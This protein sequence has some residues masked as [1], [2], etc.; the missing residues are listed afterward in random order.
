MSEEPPAK[1]QKST[2]RRAL[3]CTECKRRK[4]KCGVIGK[5]PCDSCIKRGKPGDCVWEGITGVPGDLPVVA[6]PYPSATPSTEVTVLQEQVRQLLDRVDR[7]ER[8]PQS[9]STSLENHLSTSA[10]HHNS[11]FSD[12]PGALNAM[13]PQSRDAIQASG[14]SPK[15]TR[16]VEKETMELENEIFGPGLRPGLTETRSLR[17]TILETASSSVRSTQQQLRTPRD[18]IHIVTAPRASIDTRVESDVK[19][20]D[21][22]TLLRPSESGVGSEL[23]KWYFEGP[24]HMGWHVIH[25]FHF[26]NTYSTIMTLSLE[27][28]NETDRSW[29]AIYYMILAN[30]VRFAPASFIN[31][32]FPSTTW[33]LDLLPD[34]LHQISLDELDDSD[35]Q[36]VPQVRHIQVALLYINYLFHFGDSP[37]K[38]NLALRH[39]D[40]A[41]TTA[42]WLS[43][44]ILSPS[45][46][47]L[48]PLLKNDPALEGLPTEAAI[49]LAKQLFAML[50]FLDGTIYKRARVWRIQSTASNATQAPANLTDFQSAPQYANSTSDNVDVTLMAFPGV[51]PDPDTRVFTESSLAILGSVFANTIRQFTKDLSTEEMSYE[52]ILEFSQGLERTL[53]RVPAWDNLQ[54]DSAWMIY[55]VYSSINNRILRMHR[56]YMHKGYTDAR[57]WAARETSIQAASRIIQAQSRI[58]TGLRPAF[59]KRWILGAS[60]ILALDALLVLHPLCAHTHSPAERESVRSNSLYYIST[61]KIDI[62]DKDDQSQDLNRLC[63][64]AIG[65]LVVEVANAG[66]AGVFDGVMGEGG[67]GQVMGIE[68]FSRRFMARVKRR[69]LEGEI[70]RKA[71]DLQ[72][73]PDIDPE[74]QIM[75]SI[76]G[77]N[78]SQHQNPLDVFDF[79]D[80]TFL[81]RPV[82]DINDGA[83]PVVRGEGTSG[84]G[85]LE[86]L[87]IS[88]GSGAGLGLTSGVDEATAGQ[89]QGPMNSLGFWEEFG[90]NLV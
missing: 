2:G 16:A 55:I 50:N 89:S 28:Q 45:S 14:E 62:F 60:I 54:T 49:H 52:D 5:I 78:P 57:F 76:L 48:P 40:S 34:L 36:A 25:R 12:T 41:I 82:N 43:L 29:W 81:N 18:A 32:L 13:L 39:L 59:V 11:S 44:D 31:H 38:A 90:W 56:P 17:P 37:A 61:A 46:A 51:L 30:S 86:G 72:L 53:E 88:T 67:D 63:S 3:S 64:R 19:V 85:A 24:M 74:P 10:N 71:A 15:D 77:S 83:L 84:D 21:L 9:S 70:A 87:G 22:K 26:L 20:D 42:Q 35:Y 8:L 58:P 66:E 23:V 69:L 79:F 27:E 80:F 4:T 7:L 6:G 75:Q 33:D 65:I 73:Q 47:G 1:K 68:E